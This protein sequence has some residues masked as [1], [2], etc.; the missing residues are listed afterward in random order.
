M[1]G[2]KGERGETGRMGPMGPIGPPGPPG[3]PG[4]AGPAGPAGPS[5]AA[6]PQ[7][8]HIAPGGVQVYPTTIEL[9]TASHGMPIGSLTF[10][11]S[12]Q[13]LYIRV[14]GGFKDIKLE[15]FHPIME[16]RPTVDESSKS[17]VQYQ[18]PLMSSDDSLIP[19]QVSLSHHRI[20]PKLNIPKKIQQLVP[21]TYDKQSRPD[22]IHRPQIFGT[23]QSIKSHRQDHKSL[24]S[25]EITESK[26]HLSYP[27]AEY[28][29]PSGQ[30]YP[31]YRLPSGSSGSS[32]SS[33]LS[34]LSSNERLYKSHQY[35]Q[36]SQRLD[37]TP[38]TLQSFPSSQHIS[39]QH[40]QIQHQNPSVKPDY[41]SEHIAI[42]TVA[43]TFSPEWSKQQATI[44]SP[45]EQEAHRSHYPDHERLR[46]RE[47][48]GPDRTH[49]ALLPHSLQAKDLVLHLIALNT[50]MSGNMRGVRGADLACYQQARQ[51]NF[52]TTFRAFL[53]SHV[54]D[55]NKVVHSGDRDTP[56]VNLRG[57]RL[58]DS[59]SDIFQQRQ[60]ADIPIYSF[61]RRNVFADSMWPEKRIWHG[62]DLS[63]M[64]SESGYCS[65]WRS[66]STSQVGRAS[67]I[68][69]SL[70]LLR[71]SRDSECSRELVVLCI[72][73]MSKYNADKRL[74]KKRAYF[75]E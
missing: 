75:S 60:M 32:G 41:H 1:K 63:G 36:L 29:P 15:G 5:L 21:D 39:V 31:R 56:V 18:I 34:R 26:H 46:Y 66:A 44:S 9:F 40:Q 24:I 45:D 59:W 2:E 73:N 48:P 35:D 7:P 38:S 64:R 47:R 58:F 19:S 33:G 11:I 52:R 37:H 69:R 57:E 74:G 13:Q 12:S 42:A 68:G 61:N 14:N 43:T 4:P 6:Y 50:P 20:S 16:R 25:S 27:R 8:T 23:S 30:L 22:I 71:D 53:S 70:P 3:P 17:E 67:F 54:Q 28:R 62:S 51:A 10:C 55:L 65:A 72:E 49:S